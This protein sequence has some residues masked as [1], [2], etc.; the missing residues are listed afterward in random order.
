MKIR[1]DFVTNSS[2]S[3]F[4]CCF[5]RIADSEKAS[6][7]LKKYKDIESY[8]CSEALEEIKDTHWGEW[9]EW[10]WAGINVTPD[11]EYL[12]DHKDDNFIVFTCDE[13]LEE[14]EYG[15]D[16][17]VGFEDFPEYAQE[18]VKAISE[19]NGFAD[20]DCQYGAGRNG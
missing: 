4:I 12:L 19:E 1:T 20:I 16:Y 2:S 6:K 3:S 10:D 17:N 5:A 9:L 14:T 8:T 15:C 18:T 7:V 13:D 11:E